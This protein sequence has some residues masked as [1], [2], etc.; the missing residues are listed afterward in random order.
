MA[1]GK[2]AWIAGMALGGAAVVVVGVASGAG[3]AGRQAAS[4]NAITMNNGKV[5]VLRVL[6]LQSSFPKKIPLFERTRGDTGLD[7]LVL[8]PFPR[9]CSDVWGPVF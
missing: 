8:P 5:N 9:R 6:I 3:A 2:L 4:N 1:I 7:A